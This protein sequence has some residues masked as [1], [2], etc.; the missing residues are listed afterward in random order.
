[1][2]DPNPGAPEIDP[3]ATMARAYLLMKKLGLRDLPVRLEGEIVGVIS[4]RD[5]ETLVERYRRDSGELPGR[6]SVGEFMASPVLALGARSD[7]AE[8]V[9]SMLND[10]VQA[11]VVEED[12]RPIGILRKGDFLRVLASLAERSPASLRDALRLA[13][14]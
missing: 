3:N 10:R 2:R 11:V 13:A 6:L 12:E 4:M 8:T 14:T 5:V 1:M 9:R 7:L